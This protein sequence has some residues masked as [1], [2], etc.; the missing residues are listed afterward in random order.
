MRTFNAQSTRSDEIFSV[1][2][3]PDCDVQK[4]LNVPQDLSPYYFKTYAR[5]GFWQ[6]HASLKKIL[7]RKELG[8]LL[9]NSGN[10]RFIDVGSSSGDFARLIHDSGKDIIAVDAAPERPAEI[11]SATDI[12]YLTI[13]YD[14]GR[15]HG[16]SPLGNRTVILRHLL[17][18]VRAPREFLRALTAYG[19]NE[20]YVVVPNHRCRQARFFKPYY[21]FIDPPLHLWFFSME[22]LTRLFEN[23]GFERTDAGYDTI[24]GIVSSIYRYGM[25][26][27]WPKGFCRLIRP[28]SPLNSLSVIS[29]LLVPN[30]VIW[31]YFKK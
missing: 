14:C 4:V 20:F 18:H 7:L 1:G 12:P 11:I 5:R 19:C 3:C 15:I 27:H 22:T 6:V 23:L 31:A 9:K 13:D 30:N 8:R 26:H 10:V 16:F 24:P 28:E 17:E 29:D 2:T 21:A 25:I